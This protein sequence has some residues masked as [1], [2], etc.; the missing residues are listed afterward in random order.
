[1]N[2]KAEHTNIIRKDK[3]ELFTDSDPDHGRD[4]FHQKFIKI[5][6]EGYLTQYESRL[7]LKNGK[8]VFLRP[9]LKTDK[10]LILDLFNKLCLDS[11]YLRFLTHLNA[12]PEDLLFQLTHIN[13]SNQ[14]ALVA[15]IQEEEKD[16][17]IAVAR[18]GYDP[19]ENITDFAVVVRDDWQNYGLGKSFLLKIFAIGKE[20]SISSFVSIIDS[21]NHIMKHIL[22]ELGYPVKYSY[23]SGS[24]Q[25]EVF[26]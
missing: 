24:T 3:G 23:R 12:L 17:I 15:V 25:A 4:I 11:I 10:N 5:A 7:M 1:M 20:H 18:Y 21:T 22:R 8:E 14:F 6:N 2:N 13:Y 26:I 19:K 9:I 16:S